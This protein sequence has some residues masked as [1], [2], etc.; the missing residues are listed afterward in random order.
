MPYKTRRRSFK[1]GGGSI[2]PA[3]LTPAS[4]TP[5]SFPQGDAWSMATLPGQGGNTSEVGNYFGFNSNEGIFPD[6]I[7]TNNQSSFL[8]G[9]NRKRKFINK[10]MTKMRRRKRTR[11]RKNTINKRIFKR[12]R[13]LRGGSRNMLFQLP[14]NI[15]RDTIHGVGSLVNQWSG[16]TISLSPSPTD[17]KPYAGGNQLPDT[18]DSV[19]IHKTA[20]RTVALL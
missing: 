20:G 12:R 6:I 16:K 11:Q 4:L 15:S 2:T 13:T 3:S 14:T 17:Q 7:D 10:V 1:T 5:A 9:G 19:S 8:F 18:S